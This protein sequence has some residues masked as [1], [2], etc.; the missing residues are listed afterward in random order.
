M[1]TT[2]VH[3]RALVVTGLV[4]A[5]VL[6]GWFGHIVSDAKAQAQDRFKMLAKAPPAR[7]L[8]NGES[9]ADARLTPRPKD[10][11]AASGSR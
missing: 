4:L 6:L 9:V 1:F 10:I 2:F 8:Q 11:A 7:S 5:F 3:S